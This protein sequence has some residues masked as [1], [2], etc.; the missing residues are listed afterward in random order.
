[1]PPLPAILIFLALPVS[2]LT[3]R[4]NVG[5]G[6][7]ANFVTNRGNFTVRL[8]HEK[9]PATVANFVGLAEGT[10]P[11]L[12]TKKGRLERRPFYNGL[13][14][15]RV[16]P[17]FVIQSGSPNGQGTDG[18][19]YSFGDEFHLTLP[20]DRAGILSM[21]NS[22][23]DTNG[24]QFFITLGP[25]PWLDNKHSVFGSVVD[26]LA[27]V[28]EIGGGASGET[29]IERVDISR[30][31]T[32]ALAF[33]ANGPH[34]LPEWKSTSLRWTEN[35]HLTI[36]REPFSTHWFFGTENLRDWIYEGLVID[37]AAARTEAVDVSW[38]LANRP[39]YF[40]RASKIQYAK[41]PAEFGGRTLDFQFTNQNTHLEIKFAAEPNANPV[42]TFVLN[43]AHLDDVLS[44]AM[45]HQSAST[46]LSVQL[47]GVASLTFSLKFCTET[48]GWFTAQGYGETDGTWPLFGT[49]TVR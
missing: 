48:E 16:V 27:V 29:I 31:G 37:F 38:F 6:L 39:R 11:W 10:R 2:A 18:P 5:E 49:F 34:G 45:Q 21:A 19:G 30:I 26:G 23:A 20:H 8:E 24:S 9:T 17:G 44:M 4:A 47:S 14:F 28:Y 46:L 40:F 22:G 1:M 12:D 35:R 13:T 36:E 33:D 43:G 42:G 15:H 32:S 3:A 7:F 41:R 25:T